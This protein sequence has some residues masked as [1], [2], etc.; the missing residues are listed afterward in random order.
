MGKLIVKGGGETK[1]ILVAIEIQSANALLDVRVEIP[2]EYLQIL[3]GDELVAEIRLFNLGTAKRS[4]VSIEY[5]IKD[6]NGNEILNSK[7]SLA[8]ETQ[9]NFIKRF[10][11]PER[12]NY[13]RHFLYVKGTY[14]GDVASASDE[15]E[16]VQYKVTGKEK[17]YIAAVLALVAFLVLMVYFFF[18]RK[19][20]E[21]RKI[22]RKIELKELIR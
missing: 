9:V 10:A 5:I 19:S 20:E 14:N 11:I 7:E 21:Q 6:E 22:K 4:D 3:P 8:I 13:G 2:E 1:E 15:F 12:A 18:S 16:I 17:I